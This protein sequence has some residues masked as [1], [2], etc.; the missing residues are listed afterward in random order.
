MTNAEARASTPILAAT[1]RALALGALLWVPIAFAAWQVSRPGPA[2]LPRHHVSAT[3]PAPAPDT[4]AVEAWLRGITDVHDGR[5]VRN[6]DADGNVT[7]RVEFRAAPDRVLEVPW[8]DLG[9]AE[10]MSTS[11]GWSSFGSMRIELGVHYWVGLLANCAGLG[12]LIGGL[13]WL[14]ARRRARTLGALLARPSAPHLLLALALGAGLAFAVGAWSSV[15]YVGGNVAGAFTAAVFWPMWARAPLAIALAVLLPIAQ[16]TFFRG[17]AF[18]ALAGAARRRVVVTTSALFALA[19]VWPGALLPAFVLGLALGWLRAL[20]GGLI[21]PLLA[22]AAFQVI[23]I[24]VPLLGAGDF[25]AAFA[26]ALGDV[27][28]QPR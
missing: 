12:F 10:P 21:A 22:S 7:L 28:V 3:F 20:T 26:Q 5:V 11:R 18:D 1:L 17:R 4:A 8:R 25:A 9:Y 27:L 13:G 19:H 23:T 16:E 2:P 24:S 15:P 14:G 6:D